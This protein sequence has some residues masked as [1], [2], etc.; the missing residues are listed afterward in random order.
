MKVLVGAAIVVLALA[1]LGL[2]VYAYAEHR[3]VAYLTLRA[4]YLESRITELESAPSVEARTG[5]DEQV[6]GEK[7][8]GSYCDRN[9]DKRACLPYDS[10]Q[11]LEARIARLEEYVVAQNS[12]IARL[13][14][15]RSSPTM[16]E[17]NSAISSAIYSYSIQD[18]N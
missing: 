11:A 4:D 5:E 1:S 15:A 10:G 18:G 9:P 6:G 16:S 12:A 14:S 7:S 3:E 17:V 8:Q 2:A 13:R